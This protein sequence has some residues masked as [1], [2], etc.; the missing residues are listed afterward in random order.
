MK[1]ATMV[2]LLVAAT[3][4]QEANTQQNDAAD[5]QHQQSSVTPSAPLTGVQFD[6]ASA[7]LITA[8]TTINVHVEIAERSDQRA[9]GLMDRDSLGANAGMIFLYD[10]PQPGTAGFWM[11]RTRIPLDIAFFDS[12]G[13]IVS[14][15]QMSPCLSTQQSVCTAAARDYMP[16]QSYFGALEMNAGFFESHAIKAGDRV[17]LPGRVGD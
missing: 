17:R 15:L 12:A 2:V 11:Y 16:N 3:A 1:I 9:F 10:A 6:T 7:Q 8:A 4:C 13:R 14:I 5:A